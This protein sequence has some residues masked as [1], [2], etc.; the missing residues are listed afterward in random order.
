M[1]RS[2]LRVIDDD[3]TGCYGPSSSVTEDIF[4]KLQLNQA[5]NVNSTM[6]TG[7]VWPE[8]KLRELPRQLDTL[9]RLQRVGTKASRYVYV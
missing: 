1:I 4:T 3:A 2:L 9:F 6:Y 7:S 5:I 8:S